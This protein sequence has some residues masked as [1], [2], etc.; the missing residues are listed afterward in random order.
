MDRHE[1]ARAVSE[2]VEMMKSSLGRPRFRAMIRRRVREAL[3]K[4][5][6]DQVLPIYEIIEKL[7]EQDD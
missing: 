2:A 3:K 4:K 7:N 5:L 1:K 6:W